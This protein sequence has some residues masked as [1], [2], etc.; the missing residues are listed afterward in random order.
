MV[1]LRMCIVIVAGI[2]ILFPSL[3]FIRDLG[4]YGDWNALKDVYILAVNNPESLLFPILGRH[5]GFDP[6]ALFIDSIEY[7]GKGLELGATMLFS[8]YF[9]IPRVWWPGKPLSFSLIYPEKYAGIDPAGTMAPSLLGELY[10]NFHLAGVVLGFLLLGILL[11]L[12]YQYLLK[13]NHSSSGLL[14]YLPI[15]IHAPN[16]LESGTMV[17]S[18]YLMALFPTILFLWLVKSKSQKM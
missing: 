11:K 6:I 15:V 16:I 17:I 1:R 8:L 3:V 13:R 10:V 7:S 2:F 9:W 12:C 18:R 4:I 5:C 14:I